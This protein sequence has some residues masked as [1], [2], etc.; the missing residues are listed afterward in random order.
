MGIGE[1]GSIGVDPGIFSYKTIHVETSDFRW[2]I[3][4]EDETMLDIQ[5]QEPNLEAVGAKQW[6]SRGDSTQIAHEYLPT[7]IAALQEFLPKAK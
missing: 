7:F 2:V 5:Y 4:E 3:T 1:M 6:V